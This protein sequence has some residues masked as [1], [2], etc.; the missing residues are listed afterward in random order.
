MQ[1]VDEKPETIHL[2]VVRGEERPPLLPI[3]LSVI[4]LSVLVVIALL[5]YQQPEIRKTIRVPAVLLPIQTF[6]TTVQVIPTGIKTYPAT[7][8]RGRLTITNGSV[9]SSELPKGL[10]FS[11]NGI[12]VATDSPVFVPAGSAGGYGY[13]TVAAHAFISGKKGNISAYAI[14]EVIGT[15]IYIRNLQAFRG[16]RDAYSVKFVTAQDRQ[17]AIEK[18]RSVL[19]NRTIKGL[20]DSP[21]KEIIAG[22]LSVT[23]TCQF[24]TYSVP[25]YMKVTGARISGKSVL[26]DVVYVEPKRIFIAK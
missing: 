16:G 8:A 7:T 18:G 13:A 20:L 11:G 17:T 26:V 14:N 4:A 15:S 3:F 22:N 21:C 23:W 19:L 5:P 6:S 1:T 12:E 24:V 9:I 2:Y 10:I 25:S